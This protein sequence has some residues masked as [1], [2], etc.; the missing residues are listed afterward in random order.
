[1]CFDVSLFLRL[2][3]QYNHKIKKNSTMSFILAS[4]GEHARKQLRMLYAD[5]GVVVFYDLWCMEKIPFFVC[6]C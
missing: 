6:V 5:L 4:E 2:Y 1:M 3:L